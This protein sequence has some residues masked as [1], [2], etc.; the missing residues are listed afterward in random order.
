MLAFKT[1]Q[2]LLTPYIKEAMFL[3]ESDTRGHSH[4]CPK[5][6]QEKWAGEDLGPERTCTVS[7]IP[8]S[9]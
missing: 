8:T 1:A 5:A 4:K 9:S 6:M 2:I 7:G 3:E